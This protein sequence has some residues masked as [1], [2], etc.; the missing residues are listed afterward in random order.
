M[1]SIDI[2][3]L[4]RPGNLI[5]TNT[6]NS[7]KRFYNET[8]E[9]SNL[10]LDN[11]LKNWADELIYAVGKVKSKYFL[12]TPS[13]FICLKRLPNEFLESFDKLEPSYIRLK[14]RPG[15]FKVLTRISTSSYKLFCIDPSYKYSVNLQPAIWKKDY[16]LSLLKLAKDY[17]LSIWQFDNYIYK[18]LSEKLKK[19]IFLFEA[20]NNKYISSH[21]VK[22]G[23]QFR[24]FK[25][26]S[27][28]YKKAN[29][30]QLIIFNL[31]LEIF[32]FADYISHKIHTV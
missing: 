19:R 16:L 8:I 15:A 6:L 9:T 17:R 21:Y 20:L 27:S 10:P 2:L 32:K 26:Y 25:H 22:K 14:L 5:P 11:N 7:W 4:N 23:V 29:I 30:Y 31:K 28:T 12:L 1:P 13:D 18:F 3:L 24:S